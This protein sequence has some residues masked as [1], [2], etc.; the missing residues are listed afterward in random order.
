MRGAQVHAPCTTHHAAHA[1]PACTWR[2]RGHARSC[3]VCVGPA[4]WVKWPAVVYRGCRGCGCGHRRCWWW[5][6]R[7]SGPGDAAAGT[8]VMPVDAIQ[9]LSAPPRGTTAAATAATATTVTIFKAITA[10]L[11]GAL[12]FDSL[13]CRAEDRDGQEERINPHFNFC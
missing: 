7:W 3:V 13:G 1:S 8:V 4:E 9:V 11:P 6:R 5:C 2:W 12:G 10:S